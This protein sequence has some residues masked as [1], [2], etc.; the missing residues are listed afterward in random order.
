MRKAFEQSKLRQLTET[1]KTRAVPVV[2]PP[3]LEEVPLTTPILIDASYV[4]PT[5]EPYVFKTPIS[6]VLPKPLANERQIGGGTLEP[7]QGVGIDPDLT[8]AAHRPLYGIGG[9]G[10]QGPQG[11]MGPQGII[12]STG[13]NGTSSGIPL[14]LS[15]GVGSGVE[16]YFSLSDA[17]MAQQDTLSLKGGK[18]E[19][20]FASKILGEFHVQSI[21]AGNLLVSLWASIATAGSILTVQLGLLREDGTVTWIADNAG[22]GGEDLAPYSDDHYYSF[23]LAL[24]SSTTVMPEDRLI[25]CFTFFMMEGSDNSAL[26]GG[27]TLSEVVTTL[28]LTGQAG[29]Q[30][31]QGP[32]GIMGPTQTTWQVSNGSVDIL[33]SQTVR[34]NSDQTQAGLAQTVE[35]IPAVDQAAVYFQASLPA[36]SDPV[37]FHLGMGDAKVVIAGGNVALPGSIHAYQANDIL[38]ILAARGQAMAYLNGAAIG[39]LE[40]TVPTLKGVIEV[41]SGMQ[42]TQSYVFGKLRM[43]VTGAYGIAGGVGMQGAQGVQGL[44][45]KDGVQ[46]PA[47]QPGSGADASQWANYEASN[48]VRINKHD[49]FHNGVGTLGYYD[50][51]INANFY[52]GEQGLGFLFPDFVAYPAKCQ[53]GDLANPTSNFSVTSVGN[54]ELTTAGVGSLTGEIGIRSARNVNIT[55]L[56]SLTLSGLSVNTY[57]G[58]VNTLGGVINTGGALINTLGGAVNLG[59]GNLLIAS[60]MIEV[61][62]GNIAVGSGAIEVGTGAIVI[63]TADTAGGGMQ[64]YGGKIYSYPTLAGEGGI[65]VQDA[66]VLTANTITDGNYNYLNICSA[67][68]GEN[69]V[70]LNDVTQITSNGSGMVISKVAELH[71]VDTG[72]SMDNLK[73]LQGSSSGMSLTSVTAIDGSMDISGVNNLSVGVINDLTKVTGEALIISGIDNL[74]GVSTGSMNM[75]NVGKINGNLMI[76][77]DVA[78]LTGVTEGCTISNVKQ[79]DGA[80]L[81][82]TGLSN[83]TG[84]WANNLNSSITALQTR[85]NPVRVFRQLD[86]T[87]VNLAANTNEV[88]INQQSVTLKPNTMYS[89][90][91][92]YNSMTTVSNSSWYFIVRVHPGT[93]TVATNI[94]GTVTVASNTQIGGGSSSAM[95]TTSVTSYTV[96]WYIRNTNATVALTIPNMS[97]SMVEIP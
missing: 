72:L 39:P 41:V 96:R 63:G 81:E 43:F 89:I 14:Y 1:S 67:L 68:P 75:D 18:T 35:L 66:A 37:S 30:G 17:P 69:R 7:F 47:G 12:G 26:F 87:G 33:D 52:M 8:H 92:A 85:L 51:K 22:M 80:N 83:V 49:F 58:A 31:V 88:Q 24:S 61:L 82:I 86:L 74:V 11:F 9:A 77:N 5:P 36:L 50:H 34:F 71:G 64:V 42:L 91:S 29:A 57:G 28:T 45:G 13:A 19:V 6:G 46:G 20:S 44:I 93:N 55:G 95:M 38:S 62:S 94:A 84:S 73:N 10:V 60:G 4:P 78:T 54:I 23:G 65:A 97:F 25:M 90:H 70:S 15:L 16:G 32:V 27:E 21:P 79:F 76:V 53:F 40:Y 59:A 48:N 3:I 56:G 2:L